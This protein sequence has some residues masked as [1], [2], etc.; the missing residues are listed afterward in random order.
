MTCYST[1][2]FAERIGEPRWWVL[3]LLEKSLLP[4]PSLQV[5]GGPL[6]T[7][8]DVENILAVL[9]QYPERRSKNG[10]AF[11]KARQPNDSEV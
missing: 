5:P 7:E 3:Y 11:P 9:E 1:G 6:F 4:G 10:L 8:D 2:Q